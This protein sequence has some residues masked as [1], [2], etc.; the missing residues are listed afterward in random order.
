MKMSKPNLQIALWH[1]AL[2]YRCFK[3]HSILSGAAFYFSPIFAP[4][5]RQN[6][7][8]DTTNIG[9]GRSPRRQVAGAGACRAAGGGV[10]QG[11]QGLVGG[12]GAGGG[13]QAAAAAD[14]A[15]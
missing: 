6:F 8:T 2:E 10:A 5:K 15:G 4:A 11:A 7:G 12:D 1:N 3:P 9:M 13:F 14:G